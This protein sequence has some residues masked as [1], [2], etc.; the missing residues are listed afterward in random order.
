MLPLRYLGLIH[1]LGLIFREE[2]VKGL[3][4]GY[5][6]YLLSMS[7]VV[8]M[9]PVFAEMMMLKSAYYGNYEDND[10]LYKDVM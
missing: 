8:T 1:G 5:V 7:L 9:V 6:A 2:G 3:Y 4:R 10:E